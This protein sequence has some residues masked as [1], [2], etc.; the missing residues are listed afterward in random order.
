MKS[1]RTHLSSALSV[2]V[3]LL[4]FSGKAAALDFQL[5]EAIDVRGFGSI[6]PQADVGSEVYGRVPSSSIELEQAQPEIRMPASGAVFF[7][8]REATPGSAVFSFPLGN[9]IAIEHPEKYVSVIAGLGGEWDS[10]IASLQPEGQEI[11]PRLGAG[12][13]LAGGEGSGVFSSRFFSVGLYD[14]NNTLWINPIFLAPWIVD[15]SPPVIKSA[16]LTRAGAP[17]SAY[18]ELVPARGAKDPRLSCA[19]GSY[20][21]SILS[22]DSIIASSRLYSAPYRFVVVL[23]G[24]TILDSS[25]LGAKRGDT[26]L[27]FLGNQAPSIN[28]V[29]PDGLY[30]VG[31]L[32][33]SR[34][35]HE[36]SVQ[37]S[38]YSGNMSAVKT[39]VVAF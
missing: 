26:G 34:G 10:S 23:D 22:Y 16:R 28:A 25:F 8:Q 9:M 37:V 20:E 7:V 1:E 36:L 31:T 18:A 32:V 35:D 29:T 27:S 5:P 17:R 11:I 30:N 13:V 2:L 14:A 3:L 33:L 24:K 21:L 39:R 15:R 6:P 12:A 38:D 19:Q 4:L